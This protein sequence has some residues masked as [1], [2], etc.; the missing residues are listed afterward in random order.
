MVQTKYLR[1]NSNGEFHSSHTINEAHHP[2]KAI[3]R[4]RYKNTLGE[5]FKISLEESIYVAKTKK[6]ADHNYIIGTDLDRNIVNEH[7]RAIAPAAGNDLIQIR[8][9]FKYNYQVCTYIHNKRVCRTATR[10]SFGS[11]DELSKSP[12]LMSIE[13]KSCPLNYTRCKWPNDGDGFYYP[14]NLPDLGPFEDNKNSKDSIQYFLNNTDQS[15]LS[16]PATGGL[17]YTT[18]GLWWDSTATQDGPLSIQGDFFGVPTGTQDGTDGLRILKC[19]PNDRM[20]LCDVPWDTLTMLGPG[21]EQIDQAGPGGRGPPPTS[22][23]NLQELTS[24]SIK[25]INSFVQGQNHNLVTQPQQGAQ[26]WLD[27]YNRESLQKRIDNSEFTYWPCGF[28][29]DPQDKGTSREIALCSDGTSSGKLCDQS[30]SKFCMTGWETLGYDPTSNTSRSVLDTGERYKF[31]LCYNPTNNNA[32]DL[33]EGKDDKTNVSNMQ[34]VFSPITQSHALQRYNDVQAKIKAAKKT[35]EITTYS[36]RMDHWYNA[37]YMGGK[38]SNRL[39]CRRRLPCY[40]S[41]CY[42]NSCSHS[43]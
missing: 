11:H 7:L 29:Q 31:G 23:V 12:L 17:V 41:R 1:V 24:M 36:I 8:S 25:D 28:T 9:F 33:C 37:F 6:Y 30:K 35:N 13:L 39:I 27:N 20:E 3:K 22:K 32:V 16:N 18:D 38:Y 42:N 34:K 26:G 40:S 21:P 19:V 15:I 4:L 2:L 10:K 14:S 5:I 43:W